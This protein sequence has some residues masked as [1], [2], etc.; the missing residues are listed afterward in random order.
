[1]VP[2]LVLSSVCSISLLVSSIWSIWSTTVSDVLAPLTTLAQTYPLVNSL[3]TPQCRL[4]VSSLEQSYM[5][6]RK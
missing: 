5:L 2:P 3:V 1:M 4:T 6:R